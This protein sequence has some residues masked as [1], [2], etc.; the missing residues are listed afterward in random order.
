MLSVVR[1]N[2][3]DAG[4]K[5]PMQSLKDKNAQAKGITRMV[6]QSYSF[7]SFILPWV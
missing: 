1:F 6:F 7:L 5:G 4:M 2:V 3:C